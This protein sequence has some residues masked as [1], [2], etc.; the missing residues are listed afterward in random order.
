MNIQ[1][2]IKQLFDR[3][4]NLIE[5]Q[6]EH[7]AQ[8][9]ARDGG[10]TAEDNAKW[11]AL[12]EDIREIGSRIDHLVSMEEV[13]RQHEEQR[14]QFE[15]MLTPRHESV[16]ESVEQRI[17]TFMRAALPDAEQWGPTSITVNWRG[18]P[19]AEQRD[20]TKGIA[21]AGGDLVPTSFVR[22][23]MEHLIELA[24]VRRTQPNVITTSSGENLQLPKTTAKQTAVIVGEGATIPEG[25]PAFGQVTLGSFKYA[26]LIDVSR[27]LIEDEAVDLASFL[28][29]DAGI[30]IGQANGAHLVTGTGT[31]QPEG[32]ATNGTVGKTGATGQT[33]SVTT[34]DLIDLFHSV[35]S[36]YRVRGWWLMNDLTAAFVRKIKDADNQYIWQPGLQAGQPDLL[37]GRPVVTDPNVAEMAANALSVAFGDFGRYYTIRDVG[38]VR[39]ER[40]DDFR[41][42][43]DLTAFRVIFRTDARQVI[44]GADA[45]VK[46]YQNSAT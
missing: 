1:E 43:N 17:R 24:A 22:T 40:S 45:A 12:D 3:R 41:F 20:L 28:A 33:T 10:P 32:V 15:N 39:F 29:R 23:L 11:E 6:R 30:A 31:G 36:G 38:S 44:N 37:L 8:M 18:N 27:E 25:D 2:F 35:V 46:W 26:N 13:N 16:D 21:T 5:Q 9:E 19:L 4:R 7:H 42:G 34:D 14:A